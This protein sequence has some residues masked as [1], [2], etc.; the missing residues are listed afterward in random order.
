MLVIA[1]QQPGKGAIKPLSLTVKPLE[2]RIRGG[3][4]QV[5]LSNENFSDQGIHH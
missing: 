1:L 4:F 3:P 2:P 5:I